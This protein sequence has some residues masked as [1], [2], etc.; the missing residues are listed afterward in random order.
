M[1][2]QLN[3]ELTLCGRELRRNKRQGNDSERLLLQSRQCINTL[4]T[5]ARWEFVTAGE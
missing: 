2:P 5:Q 4:H 1:F 3:T